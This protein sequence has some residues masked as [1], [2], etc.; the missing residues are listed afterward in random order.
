MDRLSE[1]DEDAALIRNALGAS[2]IVIGR[3]RR[4]RNWHRSGWARL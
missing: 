3:L 2:L 1:S 4:H